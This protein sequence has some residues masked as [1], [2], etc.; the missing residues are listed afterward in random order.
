VAAIDTALNVLPTNLR[1]LDVRHDLLA[2][3]DLIELCFAQTMDEDGKIY[4][5]QMRQ[6]AQDANFLHWAGGL[7]DRSFVP[8][9]GYVWEVDGRIIGNLTLIPLMRQGRRVH[10]IANVA[11]H[12]DFRQRGIARALTETAVEHARQR[13]SS[14]V[15][16]QVRQDNPP[17]LH[18]YQAL[19][20]IERARRA[21]WQAFP[22]MARKMKPLPVSMVITNRRRHDWE[23]QRTWLSDIYPPQ[24]AWNLPLNMHNLKPAWLGD[25]FRFFSNSPIQHW[26]AR[27]NGQARGVLTWE[28]SRM[29]VDNF[30]L[31]TT[32]D[33]EN[34]VI[35]NLL[36][37]AIQKLAPYRPVAVN[38]P[39]GCADDAFTQAGFQNHQVLIWMEIQF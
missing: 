13:Q 36:P 19:G 7:T 1:M 24:V 3:A 16:L 34:T 29:A 38:Y 18:L 39:A 20:F 9:S 8:L 15:W 26:V 28:P 10:L 17:A 27:Q 22:Y 2:V 11:V 33:Q 5:R 35:Q 30:W 32:P 21:T 14:A 23:L 12:P 4:L 37:Y 25:L 6:A 31:A